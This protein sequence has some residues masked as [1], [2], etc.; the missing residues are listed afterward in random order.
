MKKGNLFI[1]S[2]P[3]GCG[4]TTIETLLL[5]Q[6]KDLIKSVSA[7]TRKSR[8]GEK[9]KK[10][11]FFYSEKVFLNKIKKKEFLEY[12]K[13]FDNYYGTPK[14]HVMSNMKKGKDVLLNIDVKGALKVKKALKEAVLIFI[15]PPSIKELKKRLL[16]RATDNKKD[17][18]KRLKLAK[19]EM[20]LA[21]QYDYIVVNDKLQDALAKVKAIIV[22]QRC[23]NKERQ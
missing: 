18:L 1:M 12:E 2:A 11:Y 16:S 13:N 14:R 3:S 17:V 9:N 15:M 7:T 22:S 6:T 10:D 21:D 4:K 5:K 8:K 23:K 19:M 20:S